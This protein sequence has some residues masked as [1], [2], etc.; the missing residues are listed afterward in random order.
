[1]CATASAVTSVGSRDYRPPSLWRACSWRAVTS[2]GWGEAR[3]EHSCRQE[4]GS[5][6]GL[7]SWPIDLPRKHPSWFPLYFSFTL[8]APYLLCTLFPSF[9]LLPPSPS[10][11]H[12]RTF[13]CI[14]LLDCIL[15]QAQG[16]ANRHIFRLVLPLWLPP[17]FRV[18]I[19]ALVFLSSWRGK[20]KG[21]CRDIKTCRK[22]SCQMALAFTAWFLAAAHLLTIFFFQILD[23]DRDFNNVTVAPWAGWRTVW[24]KNHK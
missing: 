23:I 5:H 8:P 24:A 7:F 1:M 17:P 9:Y 12:T 14:G 13:L 22:H 19:Y 10:Q 21:M 4:S 3:G 6:L 11:S 18:W 20:S 16:R 15:P 2:K